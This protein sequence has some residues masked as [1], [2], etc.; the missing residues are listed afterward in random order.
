MGPKKFKEKFRREKGKKHLRI[1]HNNKRTRQFFSN[2]LFVFL[3][4]TLAPSPTVQQNLPSPMLLTVGLLGQPGLAAEQL[5]TMANQ[6][7]HELNLT[8]QDV[9]QISVKSFDM[10]SAQCPVGIDSAQGFSQAMDLLFTSNVSA[11]FGPICSDD[12]SSV[13]R[14]TSSMDIVQCN[15]RR[16]TWADSALD[17]TLDMSTMSPENLA[18]NILA[19]LQ[20][21]NWRKIALIT[22]SQ[23]YDATDQANSFA[24]TISQV[25][26]N[27]GVQLLDVRLV[28][29][30]GSLLTSAAVVEQLRPVKDKARVLLAILGNSLND[31]IPFLRAL[32]ELAMDTNEYMTIACIERYSPSQLALPWLSNASGIGKLDSPTLDLFDGTIL[33]VNEFYQSAQVSAF[34]TQTGADASESENAAQESVL[35]LSVQLYEC[36]WTYALLLWRAFEGTGTVDGYRNGTLLR[37]TIRTESIRGPFGLISMDDKF[38]RV[39]PFRVYLLLKRDESH[40]QLRPNTECQRFVCFS[41]S[42]GCANLRTIIVA[43][44]VMVAICMAFII[45]L[46]FRKVKRGETTQ[47]PYY[48]PEQQI[49]F[50]DMDYGGSSLQQH[51]ARREKE[52][53]MDEFSEEIYTRKIATIEQSFVIIESFR[54]REKLSFDKKDTQLLF[55][56]KQAVHDNIN[57]F[58]GLCVERPTELWVIWRHC[59]RGTLTDLLFINSPTKPI[60]PRG[61]EDVRASVVSITSNHRAQ[62][63]QQQQQRGT[64]GGYLPRRDILDNNFKSAFVRD[65]IKG[66]DFLHSSSIGYHGALTSTRCLI[67]SHWILK[68][69][70]FGT[71]RL[72]YKWR[73][74]GALSNGIG[75]VVQPLIPNDELHYY[76]PE[77]RS[78]IRSAVEFSNDEGQAHDMF[79]FGAILYEILY[80]RRIVEETT[81]SSE[82]VGNFEALEDDV[83]I[84]SAQAEERL[85]IVPEFPDE[86]SAAGANS[87]R[88]TISSV[89]RVHPDLVALMRR[90]FSTTDQRPDANM[91]RK[92]TDATLKMSGSL[93]DQMIKNMAQYTGNLE[94]MVKEQTGKVELEQ[95]KIE[96]IL[97]ELLPKWKFKINLRM[98]RRVEPQFYA[99]VTIL[100]SDIV[101]FTS[102]CSE[103]QP[104]EVVNLL[105][106]MFRYFDQAIS[107]HKAYKVETIGDAYMV[108]A[109]IPERIDSHVRE[110]AAISLMQR[111]FLFDYEIPHRPGQHLHCRWGFNSG[112]VFTGQQ[113]RVQMTLKSY[114]LLSENFPEFRCSPRGGVRI[115]GIGT[116]LTYWLDGCDSDGVISDRSASDVPTQQRTPEETPPSLLPG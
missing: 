99:S 51:M 101:G 76:A 111:E 86:E 13:A 65:I 60:D 50:L 115:E 94:N 18:T 40:R 25:L 29:T 35:M 103:S 108:A 46:C 37:S 2:F 28:P 24:E 19:L 31:Y 12:L 74:N 8:N 104:M 42:T 17:N 62:Q 56:M 16:D 93:V 87:P 72:L 77:L 79:A 116:L 106:G 58:I 64:G 9:Y 26:V 57:A 27:K 107:Q 41:T 109:G 7:L 110:I 20:M 22:C 82:G 69:S 33:L 36:F 67:D 38:N 100:Y 23:C 32:I 114:Q 91:A 14:I 61:A 4:L 55:Q 71:S 75:N 11:F 52:Q 45:F 92:I 102:L 39:A 68:L 54:L 3:L 88:S 47:M 83:G 73:H 5:L 80:R 70:G 34:G 90:C 89:D 63:Q 1:G 96:Q 43:V 48:V 85:P 10:A 81:D 49:A 44:G 21:A 97:L 15:F 112:S 6:R 53:Q 95:Q 78:T 84:F 113:D 66:L 59:F 30:N 98:G 105:N